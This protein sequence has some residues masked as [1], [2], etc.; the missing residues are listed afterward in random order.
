MSTLKAATGAQYVQEAHFDFTMADAMV[1]TSKNLTNFK[2]TSGVFDV[3]PLP[4]GAQVVGGSFTVYTVSNDS[5]TAIIDIGD[6]VVDD[7]YVNT[8]IDLKTLGST[9]LDWVGTVRTYQ[10]Y[11][12]LGEAIRV[13]IANNTGDATTGSFRLSVQFIIDG[14]QTE[15]LKTY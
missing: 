12:G 1:D 15:N 8:S 14:R 6:S 5:G 10:G 4:Y 2:A 9:N 7:R 3:I 13:T 11:K